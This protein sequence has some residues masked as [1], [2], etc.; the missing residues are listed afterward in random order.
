MVRRRLERLWWDYESLTWDA[1][2]RSA[3]VDTVAS[4]FDNDL[5]DRRVLDVG[6]G[7]GQYSVALARHGFE[8]TGIDVSPGMLRRARRKAVE[9]TTF[10]QR[11]LAEGL[12]FADASFDWALCVHVLQVVP[13]PAGFLA[14][15]RRVL[16]DEGRFVVVAF[17]PGETVA[18]EAQVVPG[19]SIARR[20]TRTVKGQAIKRSRSV[21]RFTFEELTAMLHDAGFGEVEE[22]VLPGRSALVARCKA[23]Q[24]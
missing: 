3:D 14:D 7:T 13:D 21:R 15:V 18:G 20:L 9:G 11:D 5:P 19:R 23:R 17:G 4:W 2:D 10:L 22:R 8:V 1:D 16:T 12:G 24:S 6:C